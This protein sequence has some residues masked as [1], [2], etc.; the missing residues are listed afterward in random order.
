MMTPVFKKNER[1]IPIIGNVND[2][3]NPS[4]QDNVNNTNTMENQY[5]VITCMLV[6][7]IYVLKSLVT[8][9]YINLEYNNIAS[10]NN[11]Y[12]VIKLIKI[13]D[14]EN[15]FIFMVS[16]LM[17]EKNVPM[18]KTER[19]IAR[20]GSKLNANILYISCFIYMLP[21]VI[22]CVAI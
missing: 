3:N 5:A 15:K 20:I 11:R 9:K 13:T 17:S 14:K 2:R 4:I 8:I 18:A 7:N 1:D 12:I 19:T 10:C 6:F 22:A 21:S 16:S